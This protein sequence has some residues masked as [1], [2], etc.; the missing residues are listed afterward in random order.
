MSD[1][2]KDALEAA[3]AAHMADELDSPV[4][5]TGYI[6]QACGQGIN[7]DSK[8]ATIYTGLEDMSMIVAQGLLAYANENVNR[9]SFGDWDE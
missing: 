8:W 3:L 5:L 6:L 1:A 2:T 9:L 4:M 7:E